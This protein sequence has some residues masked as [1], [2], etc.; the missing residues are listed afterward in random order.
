MVRTPEL[1]GGPGTDGPG[2]PCPLG[3]THVDQGPEP[4]AAKKVGKTGS[5]CVHTA[6]LGWNDPLR[7]F[8]GP[9]ILEDCGR[10]VWS[11]RGCRHGPARFVRRAGGPAPRRR[12]GAATEVFR[13]FAGRLIALAAE[14]DA[15]IRRKE[16]PEDVV[17]SVYRSF[18]TRHRAG[19]FD[20]GNW[21]SLW[22]L[23]TVITV[24]KCLSRA[25]YYLAS[26]ATSAGE[27]TG[28]SGRGTAGC[29]AIDRE[30][31]P[32]ESAILAET[33]ERMM[34]GLEPE[35][36][37]IIELSLGIYPAE[38]QRESDAASD[39]A[40]SEETTHKERLHRMRNGESPG[41]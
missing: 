18:F 4:I 35:I 24:R 15:R 38:I 39:R 41:P 3:R 28:V 11:R 33:V 21:D 25:E 9:A 34:R 6:G 29:E 27:V 5:A 37:T 1:R 20:L 22:G 8:P 13:R 40:T 23:L 31:T 19:Q 12:Q 36:A 17:Q 16:D 10:G 30:P 7:R 2:E 14:L 32:M 26:A